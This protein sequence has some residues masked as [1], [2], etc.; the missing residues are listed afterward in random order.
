VINSSALLADLKKLLRDLKRD[1]RLRCEERP[2]VDAPLREEYRKARAANRTAEAYEIWRDEDLTLVGVAWILGCVFVRFLEDNRLIDPPMLSGPDDRIEHARSH[3]EDYFRQHPTDSDREYLQHVFRQVEK[4]P[5]AEQLFDERHNPLWRVGLS[6]DGATALLEFFR[7]KNPDTGRLVH[8]FTDPEWDTR[9]L[10]DLY[11]DL[12]EEAK[13]KY[14]LLQTPEF[15]EEFILDRTLGPAIDEFGFRVVRLIDPACGSGHFLLGAFKRLFDLWA[16]NEPAT[17][18]RELARRTLDQIYGVDLNPYAVA[19]AR[20]RLLLV[21]LKVSEIGRLKDTPAFEVNVATGDSLLHGR[22]FVGTFTRQGKLATH[23]E[24][25]LYESEDGEKLER[26]L[27]HQYHAVVGNPPYITVKDKALNE[28][29]RERYGSCHM[30]YS[31]V[32]PF[33]E[34]LFELAIGGSDGE[35]AGFVGMIVGNSFMKREFGKKLVEEFIPR[36]DLTHVIDTGGVDIPGHGTPTVIMLGRHRPPVDRI[37][38]AVLGK[39]GNPSGTEERPGG[40][41]WAAILDQIDIVGSESSF[42]SVVDLPRDVLSKHPWSLGGGGAVDL[43]GRIEAQA[44]KTLNDLIQSVG[45]MAITGEDDLFTAPKRFWAR[46]SAPARDFGTGEVVRDWSVKSNQRA[47]FVYGNSR[48]GFGVRP[49]SDLGN[50][51]MCFWNFRTNLRNRL[52]FG[53]YQEESGLAWYEYRFFSPKRFEAPMNISFAAVATHNHFVLNRGDKVFKQSAPIVG[54]SVGSDENDHLS[55]LGLLNS[56]TASF[57]MKQVFHNKGST[58]DEKGAR[59]RTAPFEDFYDHDGTKLKQFPLTVEKPLELARA[60]DTLAGKL[61]ELTPSA[62]AQRCTPQREALD[63][64]RVDWKSARRQMIGLQEELDWRCYRL[65][66]L[67]DEDLTFAE[68]HLREIDLGERAFEIVLARK[69][70]AGEVTSTWFERHGSTPI[71]KVPAQ[72]PATYRKLVERR[73]HVIESNQWIGLIER[74]E[75]KR[76]WAVEPWKKQES[77]ALREWMLDRLEDARYWPALKAV[78]CAELVDKV[79][80]DPEFLQVAELYRGRAD[81]DLTA[82]VIE[83]IESASVPFLSTLGYTDSGFRKRKVWEGTWELQRREDEIDAR[84]RLSPSDPRHL[85]GDAAADLKRREIGEIPVPPKYKSEDFESTVFWRLRGRLDVPK[86]R[87]ISYPF[88]EREGDGTLVIG[89]AGWNHLDQARALADYYMRMKTQEGWADE[90]RIPLLA[91]IDQLVPWLKQ[92]H[93]EIDPAYE[94]RMGDF[95][96]GFVSEEARAM[97][98]TVEQVRAWTPPAKANGRVKRGARKE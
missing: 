35:A 97:G 31:L 45:F 59:Q 78:S 9:Y 55:L 39:E 8:D 4:L 12:S 72:W 58:I 14:A 10:G 61:A 51:Q 52:M 47:A 63:Q 79:R 69:M 81:F 44:T 93:N 88:C 53:K 15:V 84:A 75:Y 64:A 89:W 95:F 48:G 18:V 87:F 22:R 34:R 16:R 74:P 6:G 82:L 85:T 5:A 96:E 3:H 33:M 68:N 50:L 91:G 21:A 90:R 57:W 94:E 20:F 37:I 42:I 1:L 28:A 65:Y 77:G 56:S 54:L 49:L 38:R 43:R 36:W 2:E 66:G 13:K 19:I 40:K 30:K 27:G 71:T 92:W 17:N 23:P 7:R 80:A 98:R 25:H 60:L 70:D 32:A 11:Q 86:E 46:F 24:K 76:R 67:L 29:Y 73:I 41:A 26:I 83:L 62:L